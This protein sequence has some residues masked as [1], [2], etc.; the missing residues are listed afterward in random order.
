MAEPDVYDQSKLGVFCFFPGELRNIIY[1]MLLSNKYAHQRG[2]PNLP[3]L[4]RSAG[5]PKL[6]PLHPN[7]LQCNH[8]IYDEAINILHGENIWIVAK[9]DVH[10]WPFRISGTEG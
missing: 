1:R 7:I 2:R 10:F 6:A 4:L 5:T 9:I 3:P 8:Q